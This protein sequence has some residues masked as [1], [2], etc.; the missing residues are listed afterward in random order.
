ME[1]PWGEAFRGALNAVTSCYAHTAHRGSYFM[2]TWRELKHYTHRT[3]QTCIMSTLEN[4][5][6]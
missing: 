2:R 3:R 6:L 1:K 5:Q 4:T